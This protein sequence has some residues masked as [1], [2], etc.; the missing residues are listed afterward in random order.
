MPGEL[1]SPL[2]TFCSK[3]RS[4]RES[5]GS[6]PQAIWRTKGPPLTVYRVGNNGLSAASLHLAHAPA[7]TRLETHDPSTPLLAVLAAQLPNP[8][9][10]DLQFLDAARRVGTAV[11]RAERRNGRPR[12]Q[13]HAP[14]AHAREPRPVRRKFCEFYVRAKHAGFLCGFPRGMYLSAG[15]LFMVIWTCLGQ[16]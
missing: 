3:N 11:C 8:R 7:T 16:S 12:S 1:L 2:V 10:L 5:L 15:A 14:A 9:F 6:R 4:Q 13:L